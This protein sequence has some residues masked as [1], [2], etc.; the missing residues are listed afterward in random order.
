VHTRRKA[1]SQP[2]ILKFGIYRVPGTHAVY[3][4]A[5]H[6]PRNPKAMLHLQ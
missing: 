4:P 3:C 2:R 5:H 6:P 1:P